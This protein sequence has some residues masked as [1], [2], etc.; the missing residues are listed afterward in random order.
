MKVQE[1]TGDT[2]LS[3]YPPAEGERYGQFVPATNVGEGRS[4]TGVSSY[5]PAEGER[6]PP[7]EETRPP[8]GAEPT[9]ENGTVSPPGPTA[10]D[11]TRAGANAPKGKGGADRQIVP[12]QATTVSQVN[13]LF[14]FPCFNS[15]GLL[16]IEPLVTSMTGTLCLAA[17]LRESERD[18]DQDIF[19][20]DTLG[21][22]GPG[23][24]SGGEGI[25]DSEIKRV[26]AAETRPLLARLGL[27][28][29]QT[30]G[31]G[32]ESGGISQRQRDT[33]LSRYPPAEGERSFPSAGA[34]AEAKGLFGK[35]E[36]AW[37]S[38]H[39]Q[40][41][42]V[43]QVH[44][45]FPA[46]YTGPKSLKPSEP[47]ANT[48][49]GTVFYAARL[50][51][52]ERNDTQIIF[53][54]ETAGGGGFSGTAGIAGFPNGE[55]TRVGV[56]NPTPYIARLY[57]RQ[58]FGF[59]GGRECAPD[60][61]NQVAGERDVR[62]LAVTV[63][64]LAAPDTVDDNRYAH[65]P[66]TQFLN[67]ALVYNGAWDYP[68]NVRGYTYGAA[69]HYTTPNWTLAYGVFMEPAVANGAALDWHLLKAQGQV[70][71]LEERYQINSRPGEARFMVFLNH[72]HMGNYNEALQLMPVDPDITKT[73]SYR[74]KYGICV[75]IDQ[76]ITDD[77]GFFSRLGWN[78]GHSES[79]AFTEIDRTLSAG[80]VLGGRRWCRPYDRI[81]LAG[82]LN[83]ISGPH[84]DY[85]AAGGVGFIIGDGRLKYGLEQILET[86]YAWQVTTGI[87]VTLDFQ[88]IVNPAYNTQRG[89]VEV[90]SIRVH[91]DH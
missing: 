62:R 52:S 68:S 8:S 37:Y 71:E 17:A 61:E 48:M 86:Y 66:R 76:E 34:P 51:E 40:A 49:T 69:V 91:W 82:V 58:T 22:E 2:G 65:D 70:A 64:K 9:E 90:G 16:P 4:D 83:G 27:D 28:P 87:V 10:G 3:R 6:T 43:T 18:D 7:A 55:A 13:D 74:Y 54:P 15:T 20:S 25:A 73:R 59:G 42:V 19:D 23:K 24:T 60:D 63:G 72:A 45:V 80:L 67:W 14:P 46:P 1:G 31:S 56:P 50:C 84:R 79:W 11:G 32:G 75:S 35:N 33:G 78:D 77:L 39:A 36:A 21:G 29:L 47:A 5:P 89:P 38:A 30:F 41:T 44:N 57:V 53:N 85:L 88:E 81:G 12:A 26:G